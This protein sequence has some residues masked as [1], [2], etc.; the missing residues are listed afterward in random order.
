MQASAWT[1]VMAEAQLMVEVCPT[2]CTDPPRA[3]V[4]NCM[5]N[6]SFTQFL[7]HISRS[8]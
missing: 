4:S 5:L 1:R 8:Y 6:V 2:V 7:D 3:H